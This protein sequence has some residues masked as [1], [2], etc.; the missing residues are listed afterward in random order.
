M[1]SVLLTF[2]AR[3]YAGDY[4]G[5]VVPDI[6]LDNLPIWNVGFL[7]FQGAMIFCLLLALFLLHEPKFLPFTLEATSLFFLVRSFFMVMT[8][9]SPPS[10]VYYN[11]IQ[12]EHHR[13][14]IL[15]S[16]SSG[17]DLFFSGHAGFPFLLAL[18]FWKNPTLRYLFLAISLVGSVMVIMGHLHYTIDVFSAY[19]IA[20][21]VLEISKFL[22]SKEHHLL[23]SAL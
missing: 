12:H 13:R 15:F 7:F 17:S 1:A 10:T 2:F 19:F 23:E 9:L 14:E 4:S 11:F 21:G 5:Y 8:H 22:F 6:L 20:F 16:M 3:S 18:I